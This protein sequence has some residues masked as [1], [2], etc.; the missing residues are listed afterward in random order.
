M[1]TA[2]AGKTH[3]EG[4]GKAGLSLLAPTPSPSAGQAG[5]G[6][7]W[8]PLVDCPYAGVIAN[9][10]TGLPLPPTIFSGAAMTTAPV[11]GN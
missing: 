1:A 2:T 9:T 8:G 11:G 5:Q 7:G 6:R 3:D 10:R 4:C